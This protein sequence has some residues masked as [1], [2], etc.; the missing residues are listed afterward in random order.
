MPKTAT[1]CEALDSLRILS[2]TYDGKARRIEPF[3]HGTNMTGEDVLRAY[4]ISSSDGKTGWR[5][6][7]TSRLTQVTLDPEPFET[8]RPGYNRDDKHMVRVHCCV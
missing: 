4:Q 2:V 3:C 7:F 1:I 5:M 8:D 6:F